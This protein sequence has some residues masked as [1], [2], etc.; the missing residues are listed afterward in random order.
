LRSDQSAARAEARTL[1]ARQ[2]DVELEEV[3]VVGAVPLQ[4][5]DGPLGWLVSIRLG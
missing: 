4:E 5:D 2:F 3:L 1:A